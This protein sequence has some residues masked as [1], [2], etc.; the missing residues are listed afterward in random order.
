MDWLVIS[1]LV[2]IGLFIG[3]ILIMG[4]GAK[5]SASQKPATID[6]PYEPR[7]PLFTPAERSFLGVLDQAV[8]EKY[9][10]FGKVRVADVIKPLKGLPRP[11]YKSAFNRISSKHFDFVLCDA[12]TLKV[13]FAV[14]LNDKSHKRKK[15]A[16]RDQ[17]LNDICRVVE[18][19]LVTF[20][21]KASYSI[22]EVRE[23]FDGVAHRQANI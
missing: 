10:I 5:L 20:D 4:I 19:P 7:T 2:F 13:L 9:R 8:G 16:A 22:V 18:M 21:A 17:L 23:I 15:R 6:L 14:E 11:R 3:F 1:A 12:D